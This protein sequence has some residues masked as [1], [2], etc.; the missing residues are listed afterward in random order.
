[1]GSPFVVSFSAQHLSRPEVSFNGALDR[2]DVEKTMAVF[3]STPPAAGTPASA[4]PPL[5]PPPLAKLSGTLTLGEMTHPSLT[6]KDTVIQTNLAE[7]GPDL[8]A[9]RGTLSVTT[10]EG[11]IRNIPLAK[12]L[13][14][15]L[16][17]D[18]A[19]IPFQKI[20]GRFQ[21]ARGLLTTDNFLLESKQADLSAKGNVRMT[22]ME[23]NVAL[24]AIL[25]VGALGGSVGEWAS[26]PDGRPRLSAKVT[27]PLTDPTLRADI[28]KTAESAAKDLLKKGLE[29]W[30]VIPSSSV[31][32]S[33]STEKTVDR[34]VEQGKKALEKFFKR[35]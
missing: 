4:A 29:K 28:S 17:K 24:T 27:G 31:D 8:S 33:S 32:K 21:M 13:S 7:L 9:W 25:P 23:A 14:Q 22:D 35:R 19:E 20:S 1:M 15:F 11:K 10:A 16:K 12:K 18:T 6:V 2:L 3:G 30:G 26:G 34:A 5:G